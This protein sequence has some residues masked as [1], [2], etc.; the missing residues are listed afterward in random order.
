MRRKSIVVLLSLVLL[1]AAG[2]LF[3]VHGRS[4]WYPWLLQVRGPRTVADVLAK[5]GPDARKR[6]APHFQRVRVKYPPKR[7][8][9]L[10]FKDE[11]RVAVWVHDGAQWKF[12][13]G[14]P[15]TA[16][17]GVAGPKLRQGDYQVPEGVYRIAH[18]NP[19]SAYH[20]SMKVDY[21]NAFDR[22]RAKD[23]GRTNLG[24]D[25]FFHGK[26]V[27]V[28]CVAMGDTAIEELFTLVAET[29]IARTQVII[30]PHDVRFRP[31]A[32]PPGARPWV[33]RLYA[34][35]AAALAPF[36]APMESDGMINVGDIKTKIQLN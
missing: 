29:G 19:N 12:L 16:A 22:A 1:V 14:Y 33:S 32:P 3:Y 36:P 21:P 2:A 5:Y 15:I 10:V 11:R 7:V 35:I 6:L 28:G 30:A 23:D 17:S 25:I 31:A 9:L 4:V 8:A 26:A 13:R 18:L 27:S 34:E 24:G 20:L